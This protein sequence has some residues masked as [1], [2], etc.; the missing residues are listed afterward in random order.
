MGGFSDSE[1]SDSYPGGE[2]GDGDLFPRVR[3]FHPGPP[4]SRRTGGGPGT[5]M[6]PPPPAGPPPDSPPMSQ[7]VEDPQ[8]NTPTEDQSVLT[9]DKQK[10]KLEKELKSKQKEI[11]K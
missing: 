2:P 5:F 11:A 7:L 8:C 9:T 4:V 1:D 3:R 10:K 6:F